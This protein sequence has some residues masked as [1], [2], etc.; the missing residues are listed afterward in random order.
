MQADADLG[1]ALADHANV[2]RGGDN[3]SNTARAL[4]GFGVVQA[5]NRLKLVSLHPE[6]HELLQLAQLGRQPAE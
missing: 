5:S 3:V 6:M 2:R 4:V 1:G